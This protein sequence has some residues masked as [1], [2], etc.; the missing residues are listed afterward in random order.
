MWFLCSLK[1]RSC[2]KIIIPVIHFLV[3]VFR[4]LISISIVLFL[5]LCS[6]SIRVHLYME[7]RF[8]DTIFGIVV[9]AVMVE[10]SDAV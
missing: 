3:K 6:K 7:K 2:G 4:V 9:V 1:I 10:W 8:E 5:S